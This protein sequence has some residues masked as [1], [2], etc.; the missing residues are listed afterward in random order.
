MMIKYNDGEIFVFLEALDLCPQHWEPLVETVSLSNTCPTS[1]NYLP[2]QHEPWG[3]DRTGRAPSCHVTVSF[4]H[5]KRNVKT[6]SSLKTN[7]N[8]KQ[9]L[10]FMDARVCG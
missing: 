8:K 9:Q 4:H 1:W 2:N 5:L 3:A 7:K 6:T 10:T